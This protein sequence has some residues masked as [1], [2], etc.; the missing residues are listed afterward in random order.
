[1]KVINELLAAGILQIKAEKVV[2]KR[3]VSLTMSKDKIYII[4]AAYRPDHEIGGVLFFRKLQ[5]SND[6]I[7][8]NIVIVPNQAVS[9]TKFAPSD[10]V[11]NGVMNDCLLSGCLPFVFHCHPTI[12]GNNAYDSRRKDFY[13]R[14]SNPD[15]EIAASG[16]AVGAYTLAMPEAIAVADARFGTGFGISFY[17]GGILPH[18]ITALTNVEIGLAG[19]GVLGLLV[20]ANPLVLVGLSGAALYSFFRRPKYTYFENGGLLVEFRK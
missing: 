14:S 8:T 9:N 11:L 18:S 12:I 15:Q 10:A 1:M 2:L 19:A 7:C 5:T 20:G 17:E 13:L 4:K 6:L 3:P 16:V